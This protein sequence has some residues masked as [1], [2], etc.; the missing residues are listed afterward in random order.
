MDLSVGM[1]YAMLSAFGKTKHSLAAAAAMLRGFHSVYPVTDEERKHLRLL[2]ACRLALSCT[3]GAFSLQQ[4]PDN[5]Y[6]LLHSEPA[7][8]AMELIWRSNGCV[9]A[10]IDKLFD[11][12]CS[13]ISHVETMPQQAKP[14]NEIDCSDIWLSDSCLLSPAVITTQL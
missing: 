7:W 2:I 10:A 9:A 12:A 13:K 6:L 5:L 1:A 8:E 4:N 11:S 3:F 14:Q